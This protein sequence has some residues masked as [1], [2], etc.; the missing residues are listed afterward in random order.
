MAGYSRVRGVLR[1]AK[2]SGVHRDCPPAVKPF[3][4]EKEP[5]KYET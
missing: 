1:C 4:Q 5:I 2:A 3:N